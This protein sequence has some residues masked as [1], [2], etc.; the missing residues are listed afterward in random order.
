MLKEK[1]VSSI[2]STQEMRKKNPQNRLYKGHLKQSKA[3]LK[4]TEIQKI[5][6]GKLKNGKKKT[7]IIDSSNFKS[8]K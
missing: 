4:R 6:K 7:I 2:A 3:V 1:N 8:R 5:Q